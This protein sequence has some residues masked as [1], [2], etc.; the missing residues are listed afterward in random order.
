MPSNS[1]KIARA[2]LA[3]VAQAA[4]FDPVIQGREKP[5]SLTA[6]KV[7]ESA[8]TTDGWTVETWQMDPF[9]VGFYLGRPGQAPTPAGRGWF[10]PTDAST[11]MALV[12]YADSDGFLNL[13]SAA[14][15]VAK[16]ETVTTESLQRF[17]A[18]EEQ[19]AA[20]EAKRATRKARG[21]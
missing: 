20:K 8:Q 3:H 17:Y 18:A 10:N 7:P 1:H 19:A 21:R 13:I 4:G 6:G 14:A 9:T 15:Q 12:P 5:F 11:I 16:R 2:A